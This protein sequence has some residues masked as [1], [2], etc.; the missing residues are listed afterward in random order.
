MQK[1]SARLVRNNRPKPPGRRSDKESLQLRK[2]A[3]RKIAERLG[4][5]PHRYDD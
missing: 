5:Y 2:G 3:W 1:I 4:R